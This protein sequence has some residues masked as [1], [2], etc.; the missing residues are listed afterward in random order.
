MKPFITEIMTFAQLKLRKLRNLFINSLLPEQNQLALPN[1]VAFPCS[2]PQKVHELCNRKLRKPC[3]T[4]SQ[5][6]FP[7]KTQFQLGKCE[8]WHVVRA[9]ACLMHSLFLKDINESH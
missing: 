9:A 7:R 1:A 4:K 5:T 2:A 3:F 6:T 8:S